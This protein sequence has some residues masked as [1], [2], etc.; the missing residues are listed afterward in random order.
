MLILNFDNLSYVLPKRTF[1]RIIPKSMV[2]RF[3]IWM[4]YVK[5]SV[6]DNNIKNKR[7]KQQPLLVEP[8]E[9]LARSK[10]LKVVLRYTLLYNAR[11]G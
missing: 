1:I 4:T 5:I 10:M 2:K 8:L 6:A 7:V 11:L 9:P 3:L